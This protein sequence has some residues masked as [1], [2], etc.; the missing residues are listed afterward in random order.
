MRTVPATGDTFVS[1]LNPLRLHFAGTFEAA[2]S[3][4]NNDPVHYDNA[5]FDPSYDLPATDT[6]LNGSFNPRGSGNWRLHECTV[7]AAFLADG[8]PVADAD[9]VLHYLVADS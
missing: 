9:P 5:R 8:S 4:V 7:T 1:Y 6:A 3:T 2:V